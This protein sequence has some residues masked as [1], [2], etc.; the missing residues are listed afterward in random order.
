MVI[1]RMLED[2]TIDHVNHITSSGD[3]KKKDINSL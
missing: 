3:L 1:F 2:P